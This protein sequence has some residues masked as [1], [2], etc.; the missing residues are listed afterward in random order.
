[1]ENYNNTSSD[2]EKKIEEINKKIAFWES[3]LKQSRNEINCAV[4][5]DKISDA[6]REIIALK[7]KPKPISIH[8]TI[9][10]P[11]VAD[12]EDNNFTV[13]QRGQIMDPGSN[14]FVIQI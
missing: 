12:K 14:T 7:N 3:Q 4:L 10:A 5:V 13:L 2:V 11:S 6:K 1:M 8:S 9:D